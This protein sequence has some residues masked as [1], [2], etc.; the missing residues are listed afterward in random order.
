MPKSGTGPFFYQLALMV[1][2]FTL[3]FLWQRYLIYKM[4]KLKQIYLLL[5]ALQFPLNT[6][7]IYYNPL[8]ALLSCQMAIYRADGS[9]I[10]WISNLSMTGFWGDYSL[11]CS[12]GYLYFLKCHCFFL[13]LEWK[14]LPI[15]ERTNILCR[16][17]D[18]NMLCKCFNNSS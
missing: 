6:N 1:A 18:F 13:T 3:I 15:Q 11:E 5:K 14:W 17:K 12:K 10:S 8:L 9:I 4:L 2:S 16:L 7:T